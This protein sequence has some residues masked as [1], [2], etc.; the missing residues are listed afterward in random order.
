MDTP[1]P[2]VRQGDLLRDPLPAEAADSNLVRFTEWLER[3]SG[4][5]FADYPA[6]WQ[7]SVD[8]PDAFWRAVAGFFDVKFHRPSEGGAALASRE[9]PGARWFP[10]ATLNYAEHILAQGGSDDALAI[11][12][13]GDDP[14][15]REEISRAELAR[16]TGAVAATLRARGV[17]PGDR[18]AGYLPNVPAA[19]VAFLAAA[20]LGAVWSNCPAELSARGVVE[21]LAQIGPKVLFAVGGYRYG[22]KTHDRREAL[23]EIIAGLP[24]LECVILVPGPVAEDFGDLHAGVTVEHWDAVLDGP[25]TEIRFEPVPFEHPLWILYSSGTTGAPK[26]IVHSHGGVLLEHLKT[27][28]LQLDLRDGDRFTWY[29]SAGWMMW[30]LL[31]SGLL[32]PGVTILLYD[33]SPKHPNFHALWDFVEREGVTYFGT[34]APFL[35]ACMKEGVVPSSRGKLTTCARSARPARRCRRKRS[36]GFTPTSKKRSLSAR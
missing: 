9:M 36:A 7:W 30:N 21:R 11:I 31:V 29:T 20:S 23:R 28:S 3:T 14:E 34:S 24:T 15:R 35:T 12:F 32:L 33:G 4:Q 25:P 17:G 18:V 2:T 16:R 13:Q 1:H 27:L 6:L 19:V 26:A 5:G 10:G 8:E 22:G